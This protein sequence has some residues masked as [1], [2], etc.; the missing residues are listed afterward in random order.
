M[1]D[2]LERRVVHT[3]GTLVPL[4]HVAGVLS[5]EVVRYLILAGAVL[6]VA[7]E[8]VRLW[9]GLDW[10][11][12]DRLTRE[13]EQDNPAAYALAVAA[14]AIVVWAFEPTI[15]VPALLML[16][17][18]D[19]VAG[20][21]SSVTSADDTKRPAVVAAMFLLCLALALPFLPPRAAVPAAAV[22]AIADALTPRVYGFVVDDNFSI[23]VGAALT[24]F[25]VVTYVPVVVCEGSCVAWP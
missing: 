5:W 16:T 2:E 25:L 4:A 18:G 24:A 9:V 10:V 11:V 12:Y 13:Y 3:S 14:A 7:L 6:A 15:A 23:P 17:V 8:V 1:R 20:I 21:L 22:A 19:P